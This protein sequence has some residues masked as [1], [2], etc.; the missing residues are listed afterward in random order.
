MKLIWDLSLAQWL[1]AHIFTYFSI[2]QISSESLQYSELQE[3]LWNTE[4]TGLAP[5][6]A[7]N[8][9]GERDTKQ[10]GKQIITLSQWCCKGKV[11]GGVSTC[12]ESK[13]WQQDQKRQSQAAPVTVRTEASVGVSK[14]KLGRWSGKKRVPAL[15][16]GMW[17]LDWEAFLQGTK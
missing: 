10:L 2:Q 4:G 16:T 7:Y 15:E 17:A 12:W 1:H 14:I 11:L 9:A 13:T 8:L 5:L 3:K 6:G